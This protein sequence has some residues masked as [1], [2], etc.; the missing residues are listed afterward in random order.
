MRINSIDYIKIQKYIIL[1]FFKKKLWNNI[2][3]NLFKLIFATHNL[4]GLGLITISFA[5]SLEHDDRSSM[6][7]S[8]NDKSE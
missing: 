4:S 6:P 5:S 7:L 8:W 3:L 1:S 2:I